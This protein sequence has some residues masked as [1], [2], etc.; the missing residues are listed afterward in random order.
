[1]CPD[2]TINTSDDERE[3]ALNWG[4]HCFFFFVEALMEIAVVTS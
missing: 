4:I 1:M 2:T 3:S